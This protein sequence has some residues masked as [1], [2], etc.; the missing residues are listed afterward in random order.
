MIT[1]RVGCMMSA[2]DPEPRF[3][4]LSCNSASQVCTLINQRSGATAMH[5]PSTG[6][7]ISLQS[8]LTIIHLLVH[9]TTIF[10]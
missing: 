1:K 5:K 8:V 9:D 7:G 3:G 10:T 2:K 4:C 6:F